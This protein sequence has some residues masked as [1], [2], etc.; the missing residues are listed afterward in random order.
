[1]SALF[2]AVININLKLQKQNA[3]GGG[4][5]HS[6]NCSKPFGHC[7]WT[8][9]ASVRDGTS[10]RQHPWKS[11]QSCTWMKTMRLCS[12]LRLIRND[13]FLGRGSDC[14]I[15]SS[16]REEKMYNALSP[17]LSRGWEEGQ[18]LWDIQVLVTDL[19]VCVCVSY[20][21]LC[22][23]VHACWCFCVFVWNLLYIC[24]QRRKDLTSRSHLVK[25]KRD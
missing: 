22:V 25:R 4:E 21:R 13:L 8:S 11:F 20:E 5:M 7:D 9:V 10:G 3:G 12:K 6:N 18:F 15:M 14:T 17:L 19:C 23:Y 24:A 16:W 2:T 1:M